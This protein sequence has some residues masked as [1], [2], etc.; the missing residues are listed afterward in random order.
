MIQQVIKQLTVPQQDKMYPL[1]WFQRWS[2]ILFWYSVSLR[3]QEET[4]LNSIQMERFLMKGQPTEV[5]AGSGESTRD[6]KNTGNGKLLILRQKI[7][8]EEKVPGMRARAQ[9]R[10]KV[11]DQELQ[12]WKGGATTLKRGSY[13]QRLF[14][15][16]ALYCLHWCRERV[17]RNIPASLSPSLWSSAYTFHWPKQKPIGRNQLLGARTGRRQSVTQW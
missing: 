7:Q 8:R 1:C 6:A 2:K 17:G 15:V 10:R 16:I 13:H 3:S 9:D 14:R 12:P 4:E 5:L 11:T